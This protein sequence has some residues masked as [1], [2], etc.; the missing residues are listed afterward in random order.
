MSLVPGASG[1]TCAAYAQA[2]S[3]M[4]HT[5]LLHHVRNLGAHD[6]RARTLT[7]VHVHARSSAQDALVDCVSTISATL[8]GTSPLQLAN[9][10]LTRPTT[11]LGTKGLATH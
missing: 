9:A 8:P 3:P 6:A 10:T 4:P 5:V 11:S 1:F 2:T 7:C